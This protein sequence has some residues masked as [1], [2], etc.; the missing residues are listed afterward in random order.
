MNILAVKSLDTFMVITSEEAPGTRNTELDHSH[1]LRALIN[2]SSRNLPI[3][4]V[5]PSASGPIPVIILFF[6]IFASV[7]DKSGILFEFTFF[8]LLVK[9][10]FYLLYFFFAELFLLGFQGSAQG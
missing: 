10:T 2:V 7:K 1:T 5:C 8:L 6:K 4:S 9:L 3:S